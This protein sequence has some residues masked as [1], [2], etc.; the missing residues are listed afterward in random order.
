MKIIKKFEAKC[1]G[2]S[3]NREYVCFENEFG[4]SDIAIS[5][6]CACDPKTLIAGVE[7]ARAARVERNL[8]PEVDPEPS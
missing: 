6:W 3:K 1:T 8:G 2:C 4:W 7:Q 5:R